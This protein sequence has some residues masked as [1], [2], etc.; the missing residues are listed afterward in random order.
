[1]NLVVRHLLVESVKFARSFS[2]VQPIMPPE[3]S[4]SLPINSERHS[5]WTGVRAGFSVPP[6]MVM[7][8]MIGFGSLAKSQGLGMMSTL[9]SA[10]G[11][12]GLPGQVAMLE[13]YATGA[14]LLAILIAVAMA[15]MR[16]LPMSI[17]LMPLFDTGGSFYRW[18]FLLV[19]LMSINTWSYMQHVAP[20]IRRPERLAFFTG[21]S[22]MCFSAGMAGAAFGW[23]LAASMPL[24]VTIALIFFNPAYFIFLFC[25]NRNSGIIYSLIIGSIL[26]PLFYRVAPEWGLPVCGVVGGTIGFYLRDKAVFTKS[27]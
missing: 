15:N 1:M 23:M 26:G 14:S 21:F 10:G 4:P 24:Q 17:V 7:V 11:I 16:F 18:R 3:A 5:F 9:L 12:Y 22:I 25:T 8:A 2:A 20:D 27:S 6:L 19:Q 13:L